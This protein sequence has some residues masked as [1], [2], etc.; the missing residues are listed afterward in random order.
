MEHQFGGSAAAARNTLGGALT[1]LKNSFGDL[2][3]VSSGSS[4]AIVAAINAIAEAMPGV[5]SAVS[6]FVTNTIVGYNNM[7]AAVQKF[8]N[9]MSVDL[10]HGYASY[11]AEVR[12]LNALVEEQRLGANAMAQTQVKAT[13][14]IRAATAATAELSKEERDRIK[15]QHEAAEDMVREAEQ[16]YQLAGL[17]GDAQEALK[18]H[19]EAVNKAIKARREEHHELLPETLK[20]IEAEEQWMQAAKL[21]TIALEA[22]TVAVKDAKEAAAGFADD[23]S[24]K[25]A[26]S[27]SGVFG[28]DNPIRGF[29]E[30]LTRD[31]LRMWLSNFIQPALLA[32]KGLVDPAKEQDPRG[33]VEGDVSEPVG[34]SRSRWPRRAWGSA[35]ASGSATGSG[36]MG[37]LGGAA[38]G[39][40]VRLRARRARRRCD[41]RGHWLCR[42]HSRRRFRGERK[43]RKHMIELQQ[44]LASNIETVKAQLA[45]N[46]LGAN[47]AQE[48]ARFDALRKQTEDA[49]AT[50][51]NEAQRNVILAQLNSL[52]AQRIAQLTAEH[53]LALKR[54][55]E[56]VPGADPP[57]QRTRRTGP[58]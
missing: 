5:G 31:L 7:S 15:K 20:A 1:G 10:S 42:W 57:Q 44:S 8:H 50:G 13:A 3:E 36:V 35:M 17:Q 19:F 23:M 2:F 21:R 43:P 14:T 9:Y 16:A 41:W 53:D 47:V 18:I 49:Y 32:A 40:A 55:N 28:K 52:E 11:I 4:A 34:R 51:K 48:H 58:T 46:D 33:R 24:S 26:K 54:L 27:L 29:F 39:A 12:V 56:D 22:E 25:L 45:G 37:A 38:G 30:E 6:Q